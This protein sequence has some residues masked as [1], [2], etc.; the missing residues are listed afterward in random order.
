MVTLDKERHV[1]VEKTRSFI[2]RI[3]ASI[4][5]TAGDDAMAAA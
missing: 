5:A 4:G 3:A 1:V 2:A